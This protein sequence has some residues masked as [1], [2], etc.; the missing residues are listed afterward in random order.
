[1]YQLEHFGPTDIGHD[2]NKKVLYFFSNVDKKRRYCQYGSLFCSYVSDQFG[3]DGGR[4]FRVALAL[5]LWAL[6]GRGCSI[7]FVGETLVSAIE[8]ICSPCGLNRYCLLF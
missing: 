4:C 8:A 6:P 1:M 5:E 7:F 3:L 2:R